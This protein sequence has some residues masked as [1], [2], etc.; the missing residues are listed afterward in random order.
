MMIQQWDLVKWIGRIIKDGGGA[1]KV[2]LWKYWW[3]VI[4]LSI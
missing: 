4:D 3:T 2:G 1:G